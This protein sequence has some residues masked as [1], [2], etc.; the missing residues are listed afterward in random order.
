MIVDTINT[1]IIKYSILLHKGKDIEE[2]HV[3]YFIL[4]RVQKF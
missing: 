1:S 4:Y 2:P 3:S